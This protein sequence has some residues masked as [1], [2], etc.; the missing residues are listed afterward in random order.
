VTATAEFDVL[1]PLPSGV[2]VLEASAGT[3]KTFAIAALAA[4]FVAEGTP[5]HRLLLVTFTRT[6]TGELRERV[7]DR[8]VTAEAGLAR[9]LAGFPSAEDDEVVGALADA[10]A[11]EIEDR[12]RR[13]EVALA[14]FDAATIAT[15][16]GFCQHV[17]GGLGIGGDVE[18]DVTFVEDPTDLIEEVIDDLYVWRFCNRVEP[19]FDRAEALRIGTAAVTNPDASLEPAEAHPESEAAFRRRLALRT[20]REV[21]TRK[22]RLKLLT[23]DDLLTRLAATLRDPV[24]GPDA[25][26]RLRQRYRVAIVDEF[27]DTDTI[28][29]EIMRLAFAEPGSTLVLIGDPKQA[30]YGFRGADVHAYLAAATAAPTKRTLGTNW[31]SD[32]SLVDAYDALLGGAR[33]GHDGIVYGAVRAALGHLRPRLTGAPDPAALR[34]R[35]V[36][37]DDGVVRLTQK[38]WANAD[39]ARRHVADDLAT[40]VVALLSSA[41]EVATHDGDGAAPDVEAIRPGH[42]A[43][44]VGTHRQ[45]AIVRDALD[46]AGVPAVV[47]GAG[48]VFASAIARQWLAFLEALERPSSPTRVRSAALSVFLGWTAGRVATATDEEWDDA[49]LR[50]HRWAGVLRTRGVA[51]VLEAVTHEENLPARVLS[52]PGGERTLTDLRH[53]GQLL[54]V[55]AV[56]GQLGVTALSAWLGRRIAEAADDTA[57]EDRTRRLESDAEAVQV[58][59]I[60]ASKGLE[61]PVVYCPYLWD[62]KHI[63]DV[64]P[65]VFHDA[66][67]GDRR[68]IDV[69]GKGAPGYDDHRRLHE[70]EE[71]GEELRL[72]YVALTRAKHQAVVWWA[73]SWDSRQ[74]ALARL[75]FPPD[76]GQPVLAELPSPPTD[77][78]VVERVAHLQATAPGTIS[79]AATT[80]ATGRRWAAT[81]DRTGRL[82]VRRF[83]RPVDLTWRRTSY[84]GLTSRQA[85]P[86]TTSEP[87]DRGITDEQPPAVSTAA[88]D[89]AAGGSEATEAELRAVPLPLG[90]MPGGPRIGSLVHAVLEAVDFTDPDLAGSIARRL[91]AE[92]AWSRL[93]VGPVDVVAAGLQ[94][95]VATPLGPL[96]GDVRLRDIPKAD[97]LDELAFELP[98]VGGDDPTADLPLTAL[99]GLVDEHVGPGD[100]L[101]GYADRLREPALGQQLRG[102]LTGSIDAVLRLHDGPGGPRFAVVDYKTNWL[103][104]DGGT[105][106]GPTAWHYRPAALAEA[107]QH[108]HYPLQAL[109]YSVA[110]HRYL[111]W[112]LPSYDPDHHLAGVSY[113]FLRGM[114]GAGVPRVGGQ[115]CGV[116]SWRPAPALVAALSDLFDHGVRPA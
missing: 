80:G 100:P 35:I 116:F 108:A 69:G 91:S 97:R 29:W 21:D 81:T 101:A 105:G 19:P 55:E 85:E 84:T 28:Q 42:L 43:V 83:D 52:C 93:D 115:P 71:R 74:S 65:P 87:E 10:P 30:I 61:F 37:R 33:L 7:R 107:M 1:A 40:D 57:D 5:L 72:A 22:R 54:H 9:V 50:I 79:F 48:S 92:T 70:A 3:G 82:D 109:L 25:C 51:S 64:D 23:Y 106:T 113:L 104:D 60:Y 58:L 89:T 18:A 111:R 53:I 88:D 13:L 62:P 39:S 15:T 102:Y 45:A 44:L 47:S 6:A 63:P 46:A 86:E 112:R 31:R 68:T 12:R 20:R 56:A 41:A 99:A 96:V 73:S 27:Q 24:R 14:D 4:R 94:A 78:Q 103:G 98:L 36:H 34:V 66:G 90:T 16:H 67:A 2:T 76:A 110:L 8:L 49:Y 114:S 32:Q 59:T 26:A 38:R 77:E 75:L 11:A 17:L 95:A